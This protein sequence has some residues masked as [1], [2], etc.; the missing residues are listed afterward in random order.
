[1]RIFV[2]DDDPD[3]VALMQALLS[4][5][6][7]EVDGCLAASFALPTIAAKRPD[8][9]LADLVMAE[10]DGLEFISEI[11]GRDDLKKTKVI[12]VS[13][14]GNDH[15]KSEA[16]KRGAIGYIVKPLDPE[17]FAATVEKI[18]G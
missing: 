3:M 8:L 1:M 13:G 2:V 6:G 18:A 12:M 9:V 15:W 11:K 14:K 7:H 16:S 17:T 5:A 10:V 4:Q